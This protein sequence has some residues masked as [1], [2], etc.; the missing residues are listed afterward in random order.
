MKGTYSVLEY[1]DIAIVKKLKAKKYANNSM[2]RDG[3]YIKAIR[4]KLRAIVSQLFEKFNAEY[5]D[6]QIATSSGNPLSRGG[7]V[8]RPWATLYKE[9][10]R[11][12]YAAQITIGIDADAGCLDVG[13]YFGKASSHDIVGREKIKY[14]KIQ[15]AIAQKIVNNIRANAEISCRYNSLGDL[16]FI[17]SSNHKSVTSNQWLIDAFASPKQC[18]IYAQIYPDSED[19]VINFS[20]IDYFVSQI[21]FLMK[22]IDSS[23]VLLPPLTPEQWAKKA[24]LLAMIGYEGELFVLKKEK[25][26]V[27]LF[28]F[29][30]SLVK[31][32][33]LISDSYGYDIASVNNKKEEIYI[34]V[35][36]TTRLKSDPEAYKFFLSNNEYQFYSSHKDRYKL[37]RV[38]GVRS[39]K[40]EMI[41]VDMS[42]ISITPNGY[43]VS[44]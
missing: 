6:F 24:E 17:Y 13:F 42:S 10:D 5:G 36:T 32:M 41:E 28:G 19:R 25:E 3:E 44:I 8:N 20:T 11:K 29:S 4:N 2:G 22:C 23:K 18:Q 35:K 40:P 34:E 21:I 43:V 9:S 12:Q 15:E 14:E 27:K 26:K 1:N 30:E 38:F 7:V 37:I 39:A 31:H 33:S 16:G